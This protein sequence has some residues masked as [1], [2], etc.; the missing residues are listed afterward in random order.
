MKQ[1]TLLIGLFLF[2]NSCSTKQIEYQNLENLQILSVNS[3]DITLSADAV[4]KN[5]NKEW[6][7]VVEVTKCSERKKRPKFRA[8]FLKVKIYP[9]IKNDKTLNK[10]MEVTDNVKLSI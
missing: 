4:F 3:K 2:L 9:R 8:C 7:V 6:L 5:P 1:I 10:R